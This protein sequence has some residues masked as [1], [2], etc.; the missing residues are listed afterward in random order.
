MEVTEVV[1]PY[2]RHE[3]D[4]W[5]IDEVTEVVSPV[6]FHSEID[7]WK[8]DQE[9]QMAEYL[10]SLQTW[11][12]DVKARVNVDTI[13]FEVEVPGARIGDLNIDL[14]GEI[15]TISGQHE[16]HNNVDGDNF[17]MSED[18]F[19]EFVHRITVPSG[20]RP[21]MIVANLFSGLLVVTVPKFPLMVQAMPAQPILEHR[22]QQIVNTQATENIQQQIV[23]T[24]ATENIQVAQIEQ[25]H[26][27]AAPLLVVEEKIL[28]PA[29]IQEEHQV[30][31]MAL[32]E[33]GQN[34]ELA[35]A[36]QVVGASQEATMVKETTKTTETFKVTETTTTTQSVQEKV[37]C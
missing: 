15:L 30:Q 9:V 36:S 31:E 8:L 21:N 22:E 29:L 24:Q 35:L 7:Q 18:K 5:R 17:E 37:A 3:L 1:S 32:V 13:D 10:A 26:E 19:G 34:Q 11:G 33:G 16:E 20:L 6:I 12:P 25:S 4:Q 14:Q 23:N 27:V 2:F 28:V